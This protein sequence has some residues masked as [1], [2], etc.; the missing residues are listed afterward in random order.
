MRLTFL[1]F[2]SFMMSGLYSCNTTKKETGREGAEYY[3][4][5]CIE[6][7]QDDCIRAQQCQWN[8]TTLTCQQRGGAGAYGYPS[9]CAYYTSQFECPAGTCR[10]TG[11]NCVD[12]MGYGGGNQQTQCNFYQ[13]DPTGCMNNGCVYQNGSCLPPVNGFGNQGQGVNCLIYNQPSSCNA[14]PGC[15]WLGTQCTNRY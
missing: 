10:W 5:N 12:A 6:F 7:Y 13:N 8:P 15:Q 3:G 14:T 1:L 9:N 2:F 11:Y 4:R